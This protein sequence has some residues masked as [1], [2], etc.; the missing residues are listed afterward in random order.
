MLT[1]ESPRFYLVHFMGLQNREVGYR[2]PSPTQE[3]ILVRSSFHFHGNTPVLASEKS[4]LPNASNTQNSSGRS[5]GRISQCLENI[6]KHP[7][8]KDEGRGFL[9]FSDP[10]AV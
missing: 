8:K 4:R 3:G 1:P 9:S 6:S 2:F 7:L 5:R 10:K